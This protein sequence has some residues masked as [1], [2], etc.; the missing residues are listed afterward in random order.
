MRRLICVMKVTFVTL[1]CLPKAHL[2]VSRLTLECQGSAGLLMYCV[3]SLADN[4]EA[5]MHEQSR[6]E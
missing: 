4:T 1:T 5:Q 3:E 2:G 6:R